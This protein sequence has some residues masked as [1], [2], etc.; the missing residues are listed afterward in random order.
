MDS[1]NSDS[2]SGRSRDSG[3]ASQASDAEESD[4]WKPDSAKNKDAKY[5]KKRT[6]VIPTTSGQLAEQTV[7]LMKRIP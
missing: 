6:K 4:G 3:D 7:A 1:S 2:S 5:R